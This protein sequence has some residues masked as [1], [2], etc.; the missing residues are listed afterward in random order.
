M[1]HHRDRS[2]ID[3]VRLTTSSPL[4]CLEDAGEDFL[5]FVCARLSFFGL[6]GGVTLADFLL[7]VAEARLPW[8]PARRDGMAGERLTVSAFSGGALDSES[9]LLSVLLN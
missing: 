2:E 4:D 6:P 1:T 8:E 9:S 7:L 3:C 5:V